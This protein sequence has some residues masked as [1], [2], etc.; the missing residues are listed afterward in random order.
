MYSQPSYYMRVGNVLLI[1]CKKQKS[2]L[3]HG[4]YIIYE[5]ETI[6]IKNRSLR[7]YLTNTSCAYND[8]Y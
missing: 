5:L 7:L 3:F 4:A 2:C 8:A 1:L 6:R